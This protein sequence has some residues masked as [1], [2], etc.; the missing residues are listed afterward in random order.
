ML[1]LLLKDLRDSQN[2]EESRIERIKS[3]TS[4]LDYLG[5]AILG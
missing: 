3:T 5:K 2:L 4:W 1:N